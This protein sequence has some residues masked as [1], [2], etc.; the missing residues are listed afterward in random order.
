MNVL[1]EIETAPSCDDLR[2]HYQSNFIEKKIN[3]VGDIQLRCILQKQI[4]AAD[5]LIIL[6]GRT[7]FAEKYSEL[8]FDLRNL[9]MA[10]YSYDHRGQGMS[11]R[12][13]ADYFKGHVDCFEDYVED[14]MLFMDKVVAAGKHRHLFVLCHSMGGAVTARFQMKY[15]GMLKGIV[16]SAPMFGINTSPLTPVLTERMAKVMIKMGRGERYI[17]GGGPNSWKIKFATNPLTSSKMRFQRNLRLMEERPELALGSPTFRWLH[18]S[19][20]AIGEIVADS[21]NSALNE[22]PMVLLQGERD[23]VVTAA[24]Q[25]IFCENVPSCSLHV[26]VG[27][28]HELLMEEDTKRNQALAIIIDFLRQHR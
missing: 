3:G 17:P 15:P 27:A 23:R 11:E 24:A 1:P 18:E 6:G 25:R 16:F 12:I 20:Q 8:F 28:K 2:S 19:L 9:D 5:A 4:H 13:L 21:T 22:I 7:E 14:L 26:I 10:L